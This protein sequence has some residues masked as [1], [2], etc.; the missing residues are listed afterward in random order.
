[1]TPTVSSAMVPLNP[2]S[3]RLRLLAIIAAALLP[4]LALIVYGAE[5]NRSQDL[6]LAAAGLQQAAD[7]IAAQETL[8]VE[9]ARQLLTAMA[10]VPALVEG[11]EA[12][13]A[14][15]LERV[16]AT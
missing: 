3:I 6:G 9:N 5:R 14:D 1:M 8:V 10:V 4:V 16:Q 7:L 11:E 12:A 13:C 15:Y 2:F